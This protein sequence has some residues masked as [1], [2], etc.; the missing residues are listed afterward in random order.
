MNRKEAKKKLLALEDSE[1]RIK[2]KFSY[3]RKYI[4]GMIFKQSIPA[5]TLY[6]SGD[7]KKLVLTISKGAKPAATPVPTPTPSPSPTATPAASVPSTP[8]DD[9]FV[10]K[11]P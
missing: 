7:Y 9:D 6:H 11:I 3:S 5:N 8:P 10:G 1:L 4:K 2:W